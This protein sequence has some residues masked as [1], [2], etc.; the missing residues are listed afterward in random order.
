MQ[1]DSFSKM[2]FVHIPR[3]GG[4]WFGYSWRSNKDSSGEISYIQNKFLFNRKN[5]KKVECGRHGKLVGMLKQFKKIDADV[6]DYKK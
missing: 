6:S 4:S 2:I 1:V 3:T 5:G